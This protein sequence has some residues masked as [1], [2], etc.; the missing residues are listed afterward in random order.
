M[1]SHRAEIPRRRGRALLAEPR[2]RPRAGAH[3]LN[4]APRSGDEGLDPRSAVRAARCSI[5]QEAASRAEAA[6]ERVRA[7]RQVAG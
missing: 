7:G 5:K 3:R 4:P 1:A 6:A 2:R